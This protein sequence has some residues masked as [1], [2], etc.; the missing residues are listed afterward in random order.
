MSTRPSLKEFLDKHRAD[1]SDWNLTGM[2]KQDI[3]KYKVEEHE[4]DHFLKLVHS[5]IFGTPARAS[6]LLERHREAGPLLVD[7]DFRYETGGPLVRRFNADHVHLFIAEYIATMIYFSKVETLTEDLYFYSLVKPAAET[8]KSNQKDGIHIQ[9]PNITTEPKYQYGIRGYLLERDIIR[10]VF[11]DTGVSN[12]AEDCYDVSVIHRNNWFLYGACKQDKA[13]YSINRVWKVA[14]EDVKEALDGGDP[15][16]Y[17]EIVEIVKDFMTDTEIPP[18]SVDTM[19]MLSIRCGHEIITTLPKRECRAKEWEDLMIHWGSGKAKTSAAADEAPIK[20]ATATESTATAMQEPVKRQLSSAQ[21]TKRLREKK[22]RKDADASLDEV[23]LVSASAPEPRSDSAP[24]KLEE[25]RKQKEET[26]AIVAAESNP[27]I[28]SPVAAS[29]AA[30]TAE[31]TDDSSLMIVKVAG[32]KIPLVSMALGVFLIVGSIAAYCALFVKKTPKKTA[33]PVASSTSYSK[34]AQGEV[35]LGAADEDW[36]DDDW[37]QK[38]GEGDKP[39]AIL[40]L[41]Q[42]AKAEKEPAAPRPSPSRQETKQ[43]KP[44]GSSG[45]SVDSNVDLFAAVGVEAKPKF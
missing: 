15:T 32:Y 3:G 10:K 29:A 18:N 2:G 7:L 8:D 27:S 26:A 37:E 19:K 9:C 14:I 25:G 35:E 34:V 13:Q 17:E 45:S 5:H 4:Y 30:T 24:V 21:P 42:S 40:G 39:A 23:P 11:G 41:P 31:G 20:K 33:A 12:P 44:R 43:P 36:G 22:R 6:S 16:D 1:A 28:A 38:G